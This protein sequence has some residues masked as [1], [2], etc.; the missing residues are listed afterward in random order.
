MKKQR[1]PVM[2]FNTMGRKKQTF[3]PLKPGLVR[4]YTCGPTVYDYA[5]LGH[6][7]AYV[8]VDVL[9]RMLKFNGLRVKQVMNITD[10]GHLTSDADTGEDKIEKKAR[11][12][13][14]SA[15]K[16]AEFYTKDFFNAMHKLNVQNAEKIP[17]AT[18][19]IK[20]MIEFVKKIEANSYTYRTSDGIYFDTS[21]LSSYGRLAGLDKKKIEELRPGAR[22]RFSKEKKNVTDFALWKFSPKDK[23][24]Q[25]EWESPWGMGFPGWHL[26]CSVMGMKY[27]GEKFDIHTGGID[28]IAV[29]HT[30]EI[31]QSEAVTGK[32][33]AN[34]WLHNNF[35]MVNGEKMSKSKHNF[36]TMK[37]IEDKGFGPLAL[38]Y[39]FLTAHYRSKINFTWKS[40]KA[41]EQALSTLRGH[42]LKLRKKDKVK[43]KKSKMEAYRKEF[44][45]AINDDLNTAEAL[46][47]MWRLI[48]KEKD[49]S[50]A[51][52]RR[53]VLEFDRVFGLRLKDVK[54]EKVRVPAV[55]KKLIEKR[56]DARKKKDFE[57]ADRIRKQLEKEFGIILEDTP[58]GVEWKKKK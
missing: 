46:E 19:H 24:R 57:K 10:V 2:L 6:F 27:L 47:I 13:K 51:D 14:K 31:A 11:E 15:W 4:M 22:I 44:L 1:I 12:E 26:E 43:T 56:E 50:N 42:M 54:T 18:D 35:V 23:K 30:N 40:L 25:M 38:R 7:R 21:K 9:K 36:Y 58:R 32:N 49:I 5:H 17:K 16:I 39:L 55:A 3:K 37:D 45:K 28:H 8:F 20:E 33:P 41:S 48:R 29:H 34:F 52:K 53:L